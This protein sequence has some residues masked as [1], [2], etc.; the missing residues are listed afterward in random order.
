MNIYIRVYLFYVIKIINFLRRGKAA[1]MK[2][3]SLAIIYFVISL[4]FINS[5]FS[6]ANESNG[7][8]EI[9]PE[10]VVKYTVIF[11][12]NSGEASGNT[13]GIIAEADS[14][15]VLTKNGFSL[16]GFSFIGWN[17]EAD[18]SGTG[19]SDEASIKLSS[20]LALYAQWVSITVPT[21]S[22]EITPTEH[23][24][25]L[26]SKKIAEAG[27][28]ISITVTPDEL[29][30]L[31]TISVKNADDSSITTKANTEKSNIFTFIIGEQ[32]VSINVT[33]KYVAHSITVIAGEHGSA[34]I[35]KTKAVAGDKI[36]ITASPDELYAIDTIFVTNTDE[37]NIATTINPE[38]DNQYIFTM[39]E[40]NVSV[41]VTFKYVAH[42]ITFEIIGA[43]GNVEL[44]KTEAIAGEEIVYR[45][46]GKVKPVH[47]KVNEVN[48]IYADNNEIFFTDKKPSSTCRFIMPDRNVRI[49]V[50]FVIIKWYVYFYTNCS[51][52]IPVQKIE[53]TKTASYVL[54]DDNSECEGFVGWYTEPECINL[55]DFDNTPITGQV[56]LYAKWNKFIATIDMLEEKIN[57]LQYLTTVVIRNLG[58]IEKTSGI[59]TA[60]INSDST[61]MEY[62]KL[63]LVVDGN[64]GEDA[65]RDCTN[66]KSLTINGNCESVGKTAFFGCSSLSSITLPNSVTEIGVQA[67]GSSGIT[68]IILPDGVTKLK[69]YTFSSCKKLKDVVMPSELNEIGWRIFINCYLLENVIFASSSDWQL[70][71]ENGEFSKTITITEDAAQNA[72][73]LGHYNY[74]SDYT[75]VKVE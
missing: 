28:E 22:I 71:N 19:Y 15:I 5:I 59:N 51:V 20:N 21:Y 73:Y 38:N 10:P 53:D 60:L 33:F 35:D 34:T 37:T 57:S 9:R 62:L 46:S 48:L 56:K 69:D 7:S 8:E 44:N 11:Y 68:S 30:A 18:G 25:V 27:T 70:F 49:S 4:F 50:N 36:I 39:G 43:D 72:K 64:I 2:K 75:W 16:T 13:E 23:G 17:T 14:T 65:F 55:F 31:D 66:L 41:N 1:Y 32:D 45:I 3:T 6:C 61:K 58:S 29:Y 74:G 47:T 52:T 54:L 12:S 63:E 42:S 26:L 67:F 40:Q 24:I